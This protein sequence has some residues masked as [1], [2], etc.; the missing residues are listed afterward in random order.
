MNLGQIVFKA[1]ISF[2]IVNIDEF[3]VLLLFFT[4]AIAVHHSHRTTSNDDDQL[5]V[6]Q[7]I[8]GQLIGFTIIIIISL[9]GSVFGLFIPYKYLSLIGLVPLVLGCIELW[10]VIKFWRKQCSKKHKYQNQVEN[11]PVSFSSP[12][13]NSRQNSSRIV[14]QPKEDGERTKPNVFEEQYEMI[15]SLSTTRRNVDDLGGSYHSR[16]DYSS[17]QNPFPPHAHGPS[18]EYDDEE[19]PKHVNYIGI[20]ENLDTSHYYYSDDD[21]QNRSATSSDNESEESIKETPLTTN[22]QYFFQSLLHKNIFYISIIL[23]SD[24]SEEIAVFLPILTTVMS[25]GTG[26]DHHFFLFDN[27]SSPEISSQGHSN[28][29]ANFL[30]VLLIITIWYLMIFCQCYLAYLLI[31][32]H[33]ESYGKWISRYSKNIVPFILIGLGFLVLQDSI[34]MDFL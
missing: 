25:Q 28:K 8:A 23:L 14:S 29:L 15:S 21:E 24:G 30:I 13:I 9:L 3:I 16:H 34:L 33:Y 32:Y 12:L 1:I 7:I 2:L 19:S 18:G 6:F 4:K 5:T 11:P 20:K 31:I 27:N 22:F 10:K 26:S 17:Y